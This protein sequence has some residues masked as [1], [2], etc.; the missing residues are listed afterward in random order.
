[1]LDS[2][3][4]HRMMHRKSFERLLCGE[5]D[6]NFNFRLG[7]FSCLWRNSISSVATRT[8][9]TGEILQNTQNCRNLPVTRK[10][11][12]RNI[13]QADPANLEFHLRPPWFEL[14]VRRDA[15]VSNASAARM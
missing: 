11:V 5:R 7:S 15:R 6:V 10:F 12:S 8:T 9:A 2:I 13:K 3:N 4:G 14:D 1:M